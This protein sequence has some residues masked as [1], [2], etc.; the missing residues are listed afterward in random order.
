MTDKALRCIAWTMAHE[1]GYVA[2]PHDS[3]G[4]TKWGISKRS[5]PDLNIADLTE[6]DARRIYWGEYW[7]PVHGDTLPEPVALATFDLAVHSGVHRATGVCQEIVAD[8]ELHGGEEPHK[9]AEAIWRWRAHFLVNLAFQPG[10]ERFLKGWMARIAD[11][12]RATRAMGGR[13]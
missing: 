6:E 4:E 11:G 12:L 2:D 8:L 3:G 5:H 10:Q 9:I 1:G 7:T 13:A